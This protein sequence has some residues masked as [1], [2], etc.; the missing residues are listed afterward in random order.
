MTATVTPGVRSLTDRVMVGNSTAFDH[1]VEG[2]DAPRAFPEV[3]SPVPVAAQG[4]VASPWAVFVGVAA[5]ALLLAISP[6]VASKT[7]V[8]TYTVL[9]LVGA[10]GFV[11]LLQS[12]RRSRAAVP[13]WALAA[14]LAVGLLSALT[15]AAPNLSIFGLYLWGTGWLLWFGCAGA[16]AI[17][18]RLRS[19]ADMNWLFGGLIV[20]AVGNACL[21]LYQTLLVPSSATFGPYQRNQADGFLGNPI[22]LEA[23][24]LGVIALISVR[25]SRSSRSLVR[26]APVLLLMAVALEFSEERFAVL[27]LPVL[28]LILVVLRR[29]RGAA[30]SFIIGCGYVIGYLGGKSNLGGRLGQGTSSV[31]Y[32]ERLQIWRLAL[33]AIG[34]RPLLGYGPGLFEAATAPH[35]TA[36]LSAELGPIRLFSDAHDIFIEV[37]VTT[38][39]LGLACFLTWLGSSLFRARNIFVLFAV[40]GLAI[41]LVE[42]ISIMITPLI[43][44]TLGACRTTW[45]PIRDARPSPGPHAVSVVTPLR[46]IERLLLAGLVAGS[47][48]LGTTM[49]VGDNALEHAPPYGYNLGDALR[50]NSLLPYWPESASVLGS[51]YA[52]YA[53]VFE[54]QRR[55]RHDLLVARRYFTLATERDPMDPLEFAELGDIDVQL[56][57]HGWARRA[58]LHAYTNDPWSPAALDGLAV[59][60]VDRHQWARAS[61]F[62][63][64]E[65][66]VVSSA[67]ARRRLRLS[68][69]DV[70]HHKNPPPSL[71]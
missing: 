51:V 33:H 30:A 8:P 50:A 71:S 39:L 37:A 35:I 6:A 40:F 52:S 56:G 65:A 11:P 42:P 55:T 13:S 12:L 15:S 1:L 70:R 9:L 68:L 43:F 14:F 31:G 19:N 36:K 48:L 23:L 29:A 67:S 3:V 28:F 22:H 54:S 47:L 17:G 16:F 62:Y 59:I 25:Y 45:I 4:E 21:A 53:S 34:T 38:G 57:Q 26:W 27:L 18:A 2:F 44:L 7:F 49:L 41:E 10:V 66:E 58:F 60:A 24:M 69:Y 32:A 64:R 63:S 46:A 61:S 20:G 5:A